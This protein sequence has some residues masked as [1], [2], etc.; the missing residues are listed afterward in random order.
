MALTLEDR[1][2]DRVL[3]VDDEAHARDGYAY[4]VEDM[5]LEP[6][7]VSGPVAARTFIQSVGPSDAVICDYHL[8]KHDYAECDGD[9]LMADCFRAQVPGILCTTFSDVNFTIRRDCLRY[10]PALR[11][12]ISPTPEDLREA[13]EAC[14]REMRGIYRPERRPLRTLVRVMELEEDYFYAIVPSWDLRQKIRIY[15]DNVPVDVRKLLAPEKR[16][17]A[18]VN[19][20]AQSQEDLFF[21]DWETQ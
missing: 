21:V 10:I 2:I 1:R 17:H 15:N 11:Q 13:W 5:G 20:G 4:P 6:V 14:V 18:K 9:I 12:T 19:K 7:K 16:L 8:R 3:I